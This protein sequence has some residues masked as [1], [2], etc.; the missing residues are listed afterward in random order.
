[1]FTLTVYRFGCGFNDTHEHFE[2]ST[3]TPFYA[4][5]NVFRVDNKGQLYE[6]QI[7]TKGVYITIWKSAS[8]DVYHFL[9]DTYLSVIYGIRNK[10]LHL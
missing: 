2:F 9:N 4:I 10:K 8:E 3:T 6:M 7:L 1:M 5:V